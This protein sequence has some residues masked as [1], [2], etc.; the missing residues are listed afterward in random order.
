MTM[1]IQRMKLK[2]GTVYEEFYDFAEV[3]KIV[4]ASI[5]KSIHYNVGR[6]VRT[7]KSKSEK[8]NDNAG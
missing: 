3:G 2:Q 5:I 6:E 1:N 4:D 7:D 8:G